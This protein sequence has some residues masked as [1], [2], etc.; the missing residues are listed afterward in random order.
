VVLFLALILGYPLPLAAVQILWIN[1]VTEG[2]LTVN[3]IMDPPEGDEMTRPP[4][5]ANQPLLDRALLLRMPLMVL[6]S[7]ASTF[8]WFAYRTSMGVTPALVQTETFTVLAVCQW[9]NVLNCRS[10]THSAFSWDLF[11]NPWL[12]GGLALGNLLHLAVVYWQPLGHFFHTVPIDAEHFFEIGLVAS[13]VLWV[14]ETRKFILR[15]NL[16]KVVRMNVR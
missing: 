3:L 13:I 10:A 8:G 12:L 11:K 4:I 16:F 7:V 5:P 9:F 6:A 2:T 15:N 1:L 14:E